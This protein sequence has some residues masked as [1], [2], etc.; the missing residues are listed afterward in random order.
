MSMRLADRIISLASHKF[1]SNVAEAVIRVGD[2]RIHAKV[3]K[4]FVQSP[5]TISVLMK[6]PFPVF[7]VA[8]ALKFC[9]NPQMAQSLPS[10]ISR[11]LAKSQEVKNRQKWEKLV[12]GVSC[13][14]QPP[15]EER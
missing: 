15:S 11:S 9:P 6:S 4:A 2:A 1:A 10:L 5:E 7:V 3:V 13:E 14:W 8:T 12:Q